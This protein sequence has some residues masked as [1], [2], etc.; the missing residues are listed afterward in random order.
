MSDASPA[1]RPPPFAL[2]SL[3]S[4]LCPPPSAPCSS[5]PA[6]RS[7][8]L[9]DTGRRFSYYFHVNA[10]FAPGLGEGQAVRKNRTAS[11]KE[12]MC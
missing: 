7:F 2:S 3:P 4:A 8:I 1:L 12:V 10:F 9:F 6:P 5:L 11:G